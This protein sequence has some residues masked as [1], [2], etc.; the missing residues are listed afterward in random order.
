MHSSFVFT[1]FYD[2]FR[3]SLFAMASKSVISNSP[4]ALRFTNHRYLRSPEK[5][6]RLRAFGKEKR[7]LHK[8]VN[9]LR[10]KLEDVFE[11]HSVSIDDGLSSDLQEVMDDSSHLVTSRFPE[12][13]FQSIFWKHQM[14][15][16]HKEGKKKNGYRWH[17]R[18]ASTWITFQARH[19]KQFVNPVA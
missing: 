9:A 17:P 15:S 3:K 14:E 4:A 13:S 6:D 12:H 8:K 18:G 19:M 16:L 7:L 5:V 1:Y 2:Q 10:R 11:A